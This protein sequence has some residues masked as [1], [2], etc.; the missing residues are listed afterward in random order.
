MQ[1]IN[2]DNQNNLTFSQKSS[3]STIKN[4]GIH[5]PLASEEYSCMSTPITLSHYNSI[6]ESN[7]NL[8][9]RMSVSKFE[10][11]CTTTTTFTQLH[12]KID[13][14]L[15]NEMLKKLNHT[16]C[17]I[18]NNNLNSRNGSDNTNDQAEDED[19]N[20]DED[21]DYYDN[22]FEFSET[23]S[24]PT[25]T[26]T[27]TP[28]PISKL[29]R[30]EVKTSSNSII[31]RPQHLNLENDNLHPSPKILI[32]N[33]DKDSDSK[34]IVKLRNSAPFTPQICIISTSENDLSTNHQITEYE[35]DIIESS[36]G[37][38][39]QLNDD[40]NSS[41]SD[42][43]LN[44][45]Q[46]FF[47][48]QSNC[49][50]N[51]DDNGMN[52]DTTI[53]NNINKKNKIKPPNLLLVPLYNNG[54]SSI[55]ASSSYLNSSS[56][57]I[58]LSYRLSDFNSLNVPASPAGYS[59]SGG[60]CY[61]KTPSLSP[62][63]SKKYTHRN[64]N[65][66][67]KKS[68]LHVPDNKLLLSNSYRK[69]SSQSHLNPSFSECSSPNSPSNPM[70]FKYNPNLGFVEQALLFNTETLYAPIAANVINEPINMNLFN[71][72]AVM[73]NY[74]GIGLDAKLCL[75]FHI[76]RKEHPDKFK[77]RFRNHILYGLLGSKEFVQQT[78]KNLEQKVLLE[79]DGV[80]IPLKNVQGIVILNI[81]SYTGGVNFWGHNSKDENI[82]TIPSFDDKILEVVAVSGCMQMALSRVVSKRN[83]IAQCRSV[84]I[85]ILGQEGVPVQVD[86]EA[87]IQPPGLIYL[88]HKNR[89]QML[90]RNK[91]ILF[92]S[93]HFHLLVQV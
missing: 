33:S 30:E 60:S 35:S 28:I 5:A 9:H 16:T 18:I 89:A 39:S 26:P 31:F 44:S 50:F 63:I 64:Q 21:D 41:S 40:F 47:S 81:P 76:N 12:S 32:T 4:I 23:C 93:L 84:K 67:T 51:T 68:H 71:E 11:Q 20:E 90:T 17:H 74:F 62:R 79:C 15:I 7:S 72:K 42:A 22:A 80:K 66:Q 54:S 13:E 58:N 77:T 45:N 1:D 48:S 53:N 25:P 86:G 46:H 78:F 49:D 88:L 6:D 34:N 37:K 73:N 59:S 57:S 82:F 52:H 2:F 19:E 75:E 3:I 70:V 38:N 56:S 24:T 61:S 92:F 10:T 55:N 87:W 69:T 8:T 85:Q 91:V 14:N 43:L 36:P 29:L 27:P 83:R 65:N